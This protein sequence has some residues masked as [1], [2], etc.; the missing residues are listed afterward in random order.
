MHDQ[1]EDV[2]TFRLLNTIDGFNRK[3]IGMELAFSL[4]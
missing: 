1:L 2:Q 3:A 4:P